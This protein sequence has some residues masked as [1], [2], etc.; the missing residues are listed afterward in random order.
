MVVLGGVAV[1][2]ERSTPADPETLDLK[3][4]TLQ[5]DPSLQ[6][7]DVRGIRGGHPSGL[8]SLGL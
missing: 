3:L 6:G 4:S 5:P 1:S 8:L 2:H 7:R